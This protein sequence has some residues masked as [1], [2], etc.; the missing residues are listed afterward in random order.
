MMEKFRP[1]VLSLA[2]HSFGTTLILE[3][4]RLHPTVRANSTHLIASA[5]DSDCRRNGLNL[6]AQR[7]QVGRVY[8]YC[9]PR[10]WALFAAQ[11]SQFAFGWRGM[12]RW[13]TLR[14]GD[15]GKLGCRYPSDALTQLLDLPGTLTIRHHLGHAGWFCDQEWN[16]TGRLLNR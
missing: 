15:L 9:S 16:N 14:H 5:A 3:A 12:P 2:G 7:G 1:A 6:I 13:F 4:L 10:D 8:L 11:F